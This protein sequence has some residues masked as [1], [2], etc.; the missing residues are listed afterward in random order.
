MRDTVAKRPD[1]PGIT[2]TLNEHQVTCHC[3]TADRVRPV[4]PSFGVL[5]VL[6]VLGAAASFFA[7]SSTVPQIVRAVRSRSAEGVSW[8]S[9][10]M[11]VLAS[12]VW[13][14]YGAA[15]ADPFLLA[16][17]T[18]AVALLVVLAVALRAAEGPAPRSRG[19]VAGIAVCACALAVLALPRLSPITLALLG[20][21]VSS[22][23]MWPQ[24][25]LALSR[26]PLWGLDPWATALSWVGW[27]LW[28]AYGVA[29]DDHALTVCSV[30]GLALHSVVVAFRLPPRRTLHSIASGRLGPLA[31]QVAGP[32]SDRFPRHPDD[33]Q[34]V[35]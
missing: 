26:T 6:V 14:T 10:L 13:A 22:V 3:R 4:P 23:R 5:L 18:L 33:F 31:A 17:N 35:A 20:T 8:S 28:A 19:L 7:L 34:L 30:T 1:C 24:A 27:L 2:R 25:R 29:V 9:L 15:A 21:V 16:Y 11:N 32:V 12:A